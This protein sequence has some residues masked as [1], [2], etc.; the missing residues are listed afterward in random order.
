MEKQNIKKSVP[1]SLKSIIDGKV[2]WKGNS[3]KDYELLGYFLTCHLIIEHYIDEL[4]K[5]DYPKL[6]WE[7]ARIPFSGRLTLLDKTDFPKGYNF[8]PAVKH[9]NNLRNKISHKI[10]FEITKTDLKPLVDFLNQLPSKEKPVLNTAWE[11]LDMFTTMCCAYCG[12]AISS[13]A[14]YK[15]ITRV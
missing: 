14:H 13:V 9:L 2:N 6:N 4:L 15:K 12:G 11:I 7:D 5:I 1:P 10:D 8:L 3:G